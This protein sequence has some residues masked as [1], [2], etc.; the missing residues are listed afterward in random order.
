MPTDDHGVDWTEVDSD[1]EEAT[2]YLDS[3][4]GLDGIRE[5][6]RRSHRLLHPAPGDRI[7]DAGCGVGDDV[8]VLAEHVGPAGEVIGIDRS[9]SMIA[10]ARNRTD[11]ADAVRFQVGD[12]RQLPFEDD[13]VDAC[14]ADRVLQHLEDPRAALEE[15]TRVTRPGGRIG[16]TDPDWNTFVV[17]APGVDADVSRTVTDGRWA[18]AVSPGI[19]TR[20]YALVQN[21]GLTNIDVDPMTAAF[22]EFE[23]ANEVASLEQRVERLTEAGEVS[24]A[25]A[26]QWLAGLRQA[27][28]DDLFFCSASGFTVAG[29]VPTG[30]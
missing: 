14:R 19:G 24:T 5:Y 1:A 25:R 26:E 28:G 10:E 21:V 8:R 2:D 15:M 20:L 30:D 6:K 13:E 4:M 7:V 22:T 27:D 9:E 29:T 18:S 3:V 17:T 23:T 16:V 12:V 11:Q